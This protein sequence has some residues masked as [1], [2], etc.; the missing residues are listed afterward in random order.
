MPPR[1]TLGQIGGTK[2]TLPKGRTVS[3]ADKK[4]RKTALMLKKEQG[5]GP[6]DSRYNK[7]R[8]GVG[9]PSGHKENR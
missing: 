2:G 5:K 7:H 3:K 4:R 6:S 1:A 9:I 8:K